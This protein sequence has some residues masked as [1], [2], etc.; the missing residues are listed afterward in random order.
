MKIIIEEYCSQWPEMFFEQ[1]KCLLG[2]F[3]LNQI[4]IEHIGSTAIPGLAAKPIIDIM[5]GLI[6]FSKV[7]SL[8]SKCVELGYNYFPQYEDV[9][10][11]RRFFKK[12][13]EMDVAT[14][15]IHMVPLGGEFWDRHLLFR[16]YLRCHPDIAADY[17]AL[18][19]DLAKREWNDRNEYSDAKT[20]FIKQVEMLTRHS[21]G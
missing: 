4:V 3:D 18:K 16:D 13:N 11:D 7:G 12:T 9:M 6:D 21:N 15:H 2:K 8:V 19:K 14:H 10:P 20:E 5:V 17:G 1:R